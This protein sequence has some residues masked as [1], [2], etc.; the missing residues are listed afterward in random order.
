MLSYIS[1]NQG[2]GKLNNTWLI[3][4]DG[5]K[6]NVLN[7]YFKEASKQCEIKSF[8]LYVDSDK[9][10]DRFANKYT[11]YELKQGL[12]RVPIERESPEKP[13]E[14][15]A[16]KWDWNNQ[17]Q[18]EVKQKQEIKQADFKDIEKSLDDF[19]QSNNIKVKPQEEKNNKIDEQ[20]LQDFVEKYHIKK[21]S[22][23]QEQ[24][25]NR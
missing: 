22:S 9:A 20:E 19:V 21:L 25:L 15:K 10:G 13:F 14:I 5:L 6:D 3:S 7:H 17:Q 11:K 23:N 8:N 2:Q 16:N 18:Y 24:G 12:N 4:M 1:I